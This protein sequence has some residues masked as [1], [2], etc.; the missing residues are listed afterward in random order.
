VPFTGNAAP[1]DQASSALRLAGTAA[2]FSEMLAASPYA[3]EV[4]SDRLLGILNGV[5]AIY[6]TDPRPKNLEWM[7]RQAQSLSGR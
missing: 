3:A 4:T 1:L 6:D 7:I 5:P 2:S